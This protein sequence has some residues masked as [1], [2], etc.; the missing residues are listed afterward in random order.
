M[1]DDDTPTTFIHACSSKPFKVKVNA[2]WEDHENEC[3]L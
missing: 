2:I 1:E 3:I